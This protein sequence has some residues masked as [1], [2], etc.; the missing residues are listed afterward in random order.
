ML[1]AVSVIPR[2]Q[3]H[4]YLAAGCLSGFFTIRFSPSGFLSLSLL[5]IEAFL[6]WADT[7]DISKNIQAT[8]LVAW[9]EALCF[10]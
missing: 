5:F 7:V 4:F 1:F 10:L 6:C 9:C 8:E 3:L 2:E